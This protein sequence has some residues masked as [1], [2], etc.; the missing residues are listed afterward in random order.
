MVITCPCIAMNAA[1]TNDQYIIRGD[2]MKINDRVA[3]TGAVIRRTMHNPITVAMRGT[4]LHIDGRVARVDCGQSFPDH[5]TG[6]RWIPV[7]NLTTLP[8]LP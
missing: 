7:A 2:D 8:E 6:I 5:P 1:H 4:V 3:F